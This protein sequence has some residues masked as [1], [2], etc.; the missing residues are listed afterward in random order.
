VTQSRKQT[1]AS[2]QAPG[3][4]SNTTGKH[5]ASALDRALVRA[6]A[7]GD[8]SGID[9]LLRAGANVN[10]TIDVGIVS[11][12]LISAAR[13]G[14]LDAVRL[15]LDRGADPNLAAPIDG[16][17]LIHAAAEGHVDIVSLLLDRGASIDQTTPWDETALIRASGNGHLEVVKLLVAR[18]ADVNARA[19]AVAVTIGNI[20]M[21]KKAVKKDGTTQRADDTPKQGEWNTPLGMAER[22]GH[23]DVVAFLLASGAR[24]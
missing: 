12:P 9:E 22:G 11:S 1:A 20:P 10:C 4:Q 21:T 13:E 19:Q 16:I 8:I 15:L 3:S 5:V 24:E 23:K 17:A 2:A 6:A 7:D 18:G 14:R